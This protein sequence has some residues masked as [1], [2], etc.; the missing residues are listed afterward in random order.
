MPLYAYVCRECGAEFDAVNMIE[1]RATATCKCGGVGD[2]SFTATTNSV[3]TFPD[4]RWAGYDP[5]LGRII[6]SKKERKKACKELGV[7]PGWPT[8]K[9]ILNQS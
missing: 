3:R 7:E 4:W 6:T 9:E 8:D 1:D 5:G 2:K